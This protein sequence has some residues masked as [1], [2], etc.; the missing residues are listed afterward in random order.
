[1]YIFIVCIVVT[2][3]VTTI[4]YNYITL[5]KGDKVKVLRKSII[6]LF[7]ILLSTQIYA[8]IIE[9]G[10]YYISSAQ[11]GDCIEIEKSEEIG[12]IIQAVCEDKITQKFNLTYSIDNIYTISNLAIGHNSKSNGAHIYSSTQ[13]DEFKIIQDGSQFKIQSTNSKKYFTAKIFGNDIIQYHGHNT[14]AQLWSITTNLPS[15]ET[16]QTEIN[17]N[18]HIYMEITSPSTGRIWLDRNLGANDVCTSLND[19]TCYGDYYQWGRLTDGH[20]KSDSTITTTLATS[21]SNA[22]ESFIASTQALSWAWTTQDSNGNLRALQWSKTDGTSICPI[23]FRV[24]YESELAA[25]Q[26]LIIDSATGTMNFLKFPLAGYH[27]S[28]NGSLGAQGEEGSIWTNTT[29]GSYSRNLH[30]SSSAEW[31]N[32]DGHA[33]GVSVRCLKN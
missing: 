30:Y 20:E 14:D 29:A 10:T 4:I 24:P 31:W 27:N 1:M 5:K 28:S 22:G 12:K 18:G 6:V 15:E 23:G 8:Q 17:F 2:D 19:T 16:S 11:S 25:E 9:N 32:Q 13:T 33:A 7:S 21:I 3:I 26:P